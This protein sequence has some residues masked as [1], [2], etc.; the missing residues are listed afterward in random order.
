MLVANLR[1][2]L[3]DDPIRQRYILTEQGIGYRFVVA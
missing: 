2:K 3:D 1:H